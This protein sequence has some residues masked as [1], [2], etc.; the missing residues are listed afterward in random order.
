MVASPAYSLERYT[1]RSPTARLAVSKQT[2][3]LRDYSTIFGRMCVSTA[4][5]LQEAGCSFP[6]VESC[7]H[8]LIGHFEACRPFLQQRLC[9][10]DLR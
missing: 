7:L 1:A 10:L 6:Y 4:S 5:V 2:A 3:A 9:L 8:F